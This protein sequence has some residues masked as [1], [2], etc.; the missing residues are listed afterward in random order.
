MPTEKLTF[1]GESLVKKLTFNK[2]HI[3]EKNFSLT[4][5]TLKMKILQKQILQ[6]KTLKM[7]TLFD[8]CLHVQL[9][10]FSQNEIF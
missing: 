5:K 2:T 9:T 1:G 4:R 3:A 8:Q 10:W 6:M 7:K